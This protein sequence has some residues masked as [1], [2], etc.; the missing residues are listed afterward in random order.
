MR[1]T[2]EVME[3]IR[4]VARYLRVQDEW[5]DFVAKAIMEQDERDP[6]EEGKK[7]IEARKQLAAVYQELVVDAHIKEI[8]RESLKD[9]GNVDLPRPPA[10]DEVIPI[11]WS[12]ASWRSSPECTGKKVQDE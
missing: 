4:A 8:L 2:P 9:L 7:V 12:D 11:I 6:R 1:N 3:L 5:H 10:D